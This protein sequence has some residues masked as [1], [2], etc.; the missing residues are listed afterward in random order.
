VIVVFDSEG[1]AH[2]FEDATVVRTDEHNNLEVL[3]GRPGQE[4]MTHLFNKSEW[5][6]TEVS[7]G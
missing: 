4:R 1:Q 7:Y 3:E 2:E 6:V 5:R